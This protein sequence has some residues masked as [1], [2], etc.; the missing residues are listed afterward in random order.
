MVEVMRRSL[1]YRPGPF[2]DVR[3]KASGVPMTMRDPIQR[4]EQEMALALS[5]ESSDPCAAALAT[6]GP[7]S[8]PSV[9]MVLIRGTD[10]RGF[11][12]YTNH[13]SRKGRELAARSTAALCV[14]WPQGRV[15][16]RCEGAVEEL[17]AAESDRYFRGR[18]RGSQL[19]AWASRQS[20]PLGQRE[21]LLEAYAEAERRFA[22]EDVP[23]P[24]HWGGYVLVPDAVEFWY[25]RDHRLH[26]R[27]VYVRSEEGWRLH[28]L[29]P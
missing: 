9:R 29:Q 2:R 12:F 26:E 16:V 20:E 24:P 8:R 14:Y 6:C 10:A 17:S 22:D 1:R 4:F 15:Q 3:P 5:R 25:G 28:G 13:L 18:P 11:R 27:E 23:R 19:A 7:D 21:D